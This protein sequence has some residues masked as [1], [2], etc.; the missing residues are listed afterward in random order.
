MA[1]GLALIVSIAVT[2]LLIDW[3]TSMR[4]GQPIHED[5]TAHATKGG[6]HTMGGAAI[7]IAGA[8]VVRRV[9]LVLCRLLVC[10]PRI[11]RGRLAVFACGSA[12]LVAFLR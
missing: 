1:A 12:A 11:A 9:A 5:V 8:P 10:R 2:K 6:T 7:V 4:M 3:L